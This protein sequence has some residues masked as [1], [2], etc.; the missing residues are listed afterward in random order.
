GI[1]A[2]VVGKHVR[3]EVRRR[4][5]HTRLELVPVAAPAAPDSLAARRQELARAEG[6]LA[7]LPHD[8]RVVFVLCA[9]EG[10]PGKE[11]AATLGRRGRGRRLHEA[12]TLLRAAVEGR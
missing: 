3:T 10:G 5:A 12:R 4:A 7:E 11:G 6:A 1:A 9:I 8:L 2:N